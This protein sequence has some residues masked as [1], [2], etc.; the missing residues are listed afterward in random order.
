MHRVNLLCNAYASMVQQ[1]LR[2]CDVTPY[3]GFVQQHAVFQ[4]YAAVTKHFPEPYGISLL[5]ELSCHDGGGE[6]SFFY[7]NEVNPC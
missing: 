2:A 6:G 3:N 4:R 7:S 5:Y 1:N